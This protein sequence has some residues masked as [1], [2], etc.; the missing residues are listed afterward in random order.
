MNNYLSHDRCLKVLKLLY[1]ARLLDEKM[2]KL[3]KQNKG[4]TFFLSSNGHE[5]IGILSALTLNP[6]KDYAAP[7]YRDRP[8][9]IGLGSDILDLLGSFFARDAK[10]HSAGRMMPDH[11]CDRNLNILCQSSVVGSQFLHAVGI[12]MTFK[13]DE[14]AYVSGGDGSTSSG[15]FHEAINFACIYKLPTLFVIQDNNYA[16][17]V[18]KEEQTAGASISKVMSGFENLKI[19]DIDG[20]DYLQTSKALDEANKYLKEKKGP[21]LVVAKVPRLKA[22]SISD[23]PRRYK[24]PLVIEKEQK[25]D[26]LLKFEKFLEENKIILKD[27]REKIKNEIFN[28]IEK[29]ANEAEKLNKPDIEKSKTA[30]F[31]DFEIKTHFDNSNGEDIIMADALNHA[32]RE[33]MQRDENII[34]YGEDVADKKGGVFLVTKGLSDKFTKKRCF[35]SPL[36]ESTIIGTAIGMSQDQ[37]HRPVI[38]IQFADYLWSGINQLVNEMSSIYYR[39]NGEYSCPIVIRMPYGGY[40][41]G[42]P[43]H[44]QS[45]EATLAHIPGLKIVIPSN[46]ADAKMLLKTAIRDPNPVIFLEHKALYRQKYFAARKEPSVDSVLEF[47]KAN[48]I[49]EGDNLT[50]VCYGL[51]VSYANDVISKLKDVGY[52]IELIDLRTIVPLDKDTIINSVKKTN[53]LLIIHEDTKFCGFGAEILSIVTEE[54]FEYL[55]A[56]IKRLASINTPVSYA[57]ELEDAH[58][59]QK[60]DIKKEILDLYNY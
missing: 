21:C 3:V 23:D 5:L 20:T 60:E 16:I 27:E 42:G 26:P 41:Q 8:F 39:S 54:A 15:D 9:V 1:T 6:K 46:A 56:P 12:S 4:T 35:N 57:K 58:F 22:H 17:S 7:Y 38:E 31:K 43:Y 59:V 50:V 47:K 49:N 34:V 40:I 28:F 32:L 52:S 48:I 53:K 2:E 18:T 13:N 33:E 14:I 11:F 30:I 44:S 45:I 19:F 36:A 24:D 37:K 10:H 25:E 55:D 51:M 29:K